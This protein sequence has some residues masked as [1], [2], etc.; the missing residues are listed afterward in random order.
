[1]KS[2]TIINNN[3]I[4]TTYYLN[5][6]FT[7]HLKIKV[8]EVCLIHIYKFHNHRYDLRLFDYFNENIYVRDNLRSLNV[9]RDTIYSLIRISPYQ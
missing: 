9:V 4:A 2:V 5:F 1:M 6:S 8:D 3:F 7:N